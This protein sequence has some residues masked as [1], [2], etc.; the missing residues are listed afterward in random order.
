MHGGARRTGITIEL[1]WTTRYDHQ[2]TMA[3]CGHCGT[4]VTEQESACPACGQPIGAKST[5]ARFKGT[6]M[7][8]GGRLQAAAPA[9]PVAAPPAIAEPASEQLIAPAAAAIAAAPHAVSTRKKGTI[10]GVGLPALDPTPA[11]AATPPAES[12]RPPPVAAPP[13]RPPAD[14]IV[15]QP[16]VSAKRALPDPAVAATDSA[17]R[18]VGHFVA[19]SVPPPL[20]KQGGSR[21]VAIG[22]GGMALIATAGYLVAQFLGLIH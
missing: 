8:A 12:P 4:G 19:G 3:F 5:G 18:P 9:D 20:A 15:G 1:R 16:L 13:P 21:W 11:S 14:A 6:M 22:L 7:T 10:R 2:L 17:R